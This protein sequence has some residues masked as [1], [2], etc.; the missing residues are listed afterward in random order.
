MIDSHH[1]S[2]SSAPAPPVQQY[3]P[4]RQS[5][6][7]SAPPPRAEQS[8]PM[9]RKFQDTDA[10]PRDVQQQSK[11]KFPQPEAYTPVVEE[12]KHEEKP[13]QEEVIQPQ[14][15]DLENNVDE[16][17]QEE[18]HQQQPQEEYENE[19]QQEQY[20]DDDLQQQQHQHPDEYAVGPED[21]EEN[22][23][24][25]QIHNVQ[26]QEEECEQDVQLQQEDAHAVQAAAPVNKRVSPR[27]LIHAED[28]A[29]YHKLPTHAPYQHDGP[30]CD[31]CRSPFPPRDESDI[32]YYCHNPKVK[33]T[34]KEEEDG[35]EFHSHPRQD[36]FPPGIPKS[37]TF[38][39]AVGGDSEHEE[40]V[41]LAH[42]SRRTH[43]H[44]TTTDWINEQTW[45]AERNQEL[46]RDR[47]RERE[48]E[49]ERQRAEL[50]EQHMMLE[51]E[52]LSL[53]RQ[54]LQMELEMKD[55]EEYLLLSSR[56]RSGRF[57]SKLA[58]AVTATED[59]SMRMPTADAHVGD[60]VKQEAVTFGSA[61]VH[62]RPHEH[63]EKRRSREHRHSSSRRR[64]GK[65]SEVIESTTVSAE[66]QSAVGGSAEADGAASVGVGQLVKVTEVLREEKVAIG[67]PDGKSKVVPVSQE[68][69][70]ILRQF[71]TMLRTQPILTKYSQWFSHPYRF[72][73]V[74]QR[75]HWKYDTDK[76][77]YIDL[78][79]IRSV[80]DN[81][82]N[83]SRV[84]RWKKKISDRAFCIKTDL[85]TVVL[86]AASKEQ[87]ELWIKGLTLFCK[88]I[89]S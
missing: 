55:Q 70:Q 18:Y 39:V 47:E 40:E 9:K 22:S 11:K 35:N 12:Q 32:C 10:S 80:D 85:K 44:L 2:V 61:S 64:T 53:E 49:R 52:K 86:E 54:K 74:E 79:A 50:E 59:E 78:T 88:H 58:A 23:Y 84:W 7:S 28:D 37:R 17:P 42:Q 76:S 66:Q 33:P 3:Q 19:E 5:A 83:P 4:S 89:R 21:P 82:D 29:S 69:F 65:S 13:Q 48:R 57:S 60:E 34:V 14:Q 87:K 27:Q 77:R 73:Q 30:K 1:H 46:E 45:E 67:H 63:D 36:P 75:L 41:E 6:V 71:A 68:D 26:E 56:K 20:Y 43:R 24:Y 16:Q 51:R 15:D 8:H 31:R 72:V 25:N 81:P 62:S 38:D